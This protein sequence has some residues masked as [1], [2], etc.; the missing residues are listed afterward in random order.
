MGSAEFGPATS[1]HVLSSYRDSIHWN[2]SKRAYILT[3]GVSGVDVAHYRHKLPEYVYDVYTLVE[4]N[5]VCSSNA[6]NVQSNRK[7]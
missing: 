3:H 4:R 6:L 1:A 5:S 7:H 2:E